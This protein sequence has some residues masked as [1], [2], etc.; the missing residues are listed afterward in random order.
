[1]DRQPLAIRYMHKST[2]L[3]FSPMTAAV[4]AQLR[5]GD[6]EPPC[7]RATLRELLRESR[8]LHHAESLSSTTTA[9]AVAHVERPGSL[10]AAASIGGIHESG[11]Y[12]A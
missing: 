4:P 8:N 6:G 9:Q 11:M 2:R 1:M 7:F 12:I 3:R 5:P 10:F